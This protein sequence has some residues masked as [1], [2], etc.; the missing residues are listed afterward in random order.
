MSGLRDVYSCA[1]E[2]GSCSLQ[3]VTAQFDSTATHPRFFTVFDGKL[4]FVAMDR[5]LATGLELY[6]L[7]QVK[8][9]KK[10]KRMNYL[11]KGNNQVSGDKT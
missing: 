7:D 5:Q 3:R 11:K 1:C 8:K 4:I 9:K 2:G 6:S 10:K